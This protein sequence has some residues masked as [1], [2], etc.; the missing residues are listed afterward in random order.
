[1]HGKRRLT[2]HSPYNSPLP[3]SSVLIVGGYVFS[4]QCSEGVLEN[5]PGVYVVLDIDMHGQVAKYI[6]VG[7]SEQVR[8][9]VEQHDRVKCWDRHTGGVRAFA[10]LY[11]DGYGDDYRRGIEKNLRGSLSLPCGDR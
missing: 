4:D 7:E 8:D 5:R 1:M 2:A 9:R 10:V 6:D 11:T 3:L